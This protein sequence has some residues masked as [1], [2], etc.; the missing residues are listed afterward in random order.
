MEQPTSFTARFLRPVRKSNTNSAP[1]AE[2]E[3]PARP[4][5]D[6]L[7]V[8][9][10]ISMPSPNRPANC[11]TSTLD[12]VDEDEEDIPDIAFGVCRLPYKS[13]KQPPIS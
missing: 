4:K 9:V 11:S 6:M 13:P 8:A 3:K 1:P 12:K 5:I 10:L 7:Q 2:L